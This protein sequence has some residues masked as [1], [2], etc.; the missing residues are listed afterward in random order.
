MARR[1]RAVSEPAEDEQWSRRA[2]LAA[3]TAGSMLS[4][5]GC[6]YVPDF[7]RKPEVTDAFLEIN[8]RNNVGMLQLTI[9]G[10]E[11]EQVADTIDQNNAFHT[12]ADVKY[13]APDGDTLTIAFADF[14]KKYDIAGG[15]VYSHPPIA[16][17]EAPVTIPDDAVLDIEYTDL[18]VSLQSD[19]SEASEY[20]E[21]VNWEMSYKFSN[22]TAESTPVRRHAT[23][24]ELR[25]ST[26][27]QRYQWN[28]SY[29]QF[30]NVDREY[31]LRVLE[32]KTYLEDTRPADTVNQYFNGNVDWKTGSDRLRYQPCEYDALDICSE[33]TLADPPWEYYNNRSESNQ[34]PGTSAIDSP[35]IIQLNS[36]AWTRYQLAL[37]LETALER[38]SV[39]EE[40]IGDSTSQFM[41]SLGNKLINAFSMSVP[42]RNPS[43]KII[44]ESMKTVTSVYTLI[45][46]TQGFNESREGES[47]LAESTEK[48]LEDHYKLY[49]QKLSPMRWYNKE[50]SIWISFKH[51]RVLAAIEI[52]EALTE[53]QLAGQSPR[54]TYAKAWYHDLLLQQLAI[55]HTISG[56]FQAF[57]K[58]PFEDL[59][60][61]GM[62][63][64]LQ[65]VIEICDKYISSLERSIEILGDFPDEIGP[66]DETAIS[67]MEP[68]TIEDIKILKNTVEVGEPTPIK[69]TV[70]NDSTS[71]QEFVLS[72]QLGDGREKKLISSD[73]ISGGETIEI[74]GY[75]TYNEPG[76]YTPT[77]DG[78]NL[79][80]V[81]VTEYDMP[82]S[83]NYPNRGYL[84]TNIMYNPETE[85]L[86]T[87]KIGDSPPVRWRY[88]V[89]HENQYL[90]RPILVDGTLYVP[91]IDKL[92]ALDPATGSEQW[93][94]ELDGNAAMTPTYMNGRLYETDYD[95][96]I[97]AL[98]PSTGKIITQNS[99]RQYAWSV[100]PGDDAIYAYN[101]TEQFDR[102]QPSLVK[103]DNKLNKQWEKTLTTG[104]YSRPAV[105]DGLAVLG[106]TDKVGAYDQ[107]TGE[108]VW[109]ESR[110]WSN[111]P[112]A[113]H[114][115]NVYSVGWKG[116]PE[117]TVVIYNLK[118]GEKIAGNDT[119]FGL[120]TT[121]HIADGV[122]FAGGNRGIYAFDTDTLEK[123]Y[124]FPMGS[125]DSS[126]TKPFVVTDGHII[127]TNEAGL[128]RCFE[129]STQ[130][131]VWEFQ[132]DEATKGVLAAGEQ[133]FIVA[134]TR[135]IALG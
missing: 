135:Y 72:V 28:P 94:T 31:G 2:I 83:Q 116:Y 54:Y 34:I 35:T 15:A 23:I 14:A 48:M 64:E 96:N 123:L 82:S 112:V 97:Y 103:F 110:A 17:N 33:L 58:Y 92:A 81:T 111:R 87:V 70:T 131:V 90:N 29:E 42:G 102:T 11:A 119:S 63:E 19:T 65:V 16:L 115:G 9:E 25:N 61:E 1:K 118:T 57:L 126:S 68:F 134:D 91:A 76:T 79:G 104:F 37:T 13:I 32:T 105:S 117:D 106:I 3:A 39:D 128:V 47:G 24:D 50:S 55:V 53:F 101:Q 89:T 78:T 60:V 85:A 113:I 130:E 10:G 12:E 67:D 51:V 127:A 100:T 6:S 8:T 18:N 44:F 26:I 121:P 71:K 107:K 40:E 80:T 30:D 45:A 7:L 52:T 122:M 129:R 5:A 125:T 95:G 99:M 69:T 59:D 132:M 73:V 98:D 93:V 120:Y 88:E 74:D 114:S 43:P 56:G 62:E 21:E 22:V 49:S 66:D 84:P 20:I 41:N 77:A 36:E 27:D 46:E 109:T 75:L 86:T 133:V 4:L 108:V 38:I 124:I